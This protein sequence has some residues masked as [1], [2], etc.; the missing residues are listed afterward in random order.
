MAAELPRKQLQ[1]CGKQD[2]SSAQPPAALPCQPSVPAGAAAWDPPGRRPAQQAYVWLQH[3]QK[4]TQVWLKAQQVAAKRCCHDYHLTWL[5]LNWSDK[6][7][8]SSYTAIHAHS[9]VL[10]KTPPKGFIPPI[11]SESLCRNH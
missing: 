4:N 9:C 5:P 1:G 7:H 10:A 8:C 6:R 3:V 2:D 11:C